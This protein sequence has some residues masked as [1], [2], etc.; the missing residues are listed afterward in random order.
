[1]YI[2]SAY[3]ISAAQ[4]AGLMKKFT[5]TMNFLVKQGIIE[6]FKIDS[7]SLGQDRQVWFD[8]PYD[9]KTLQM[10]FFVANNLEEIS[11]KD[12][13]NGSMLILTT[14][15]SCDDIKS[16]VDNSKQKRIKGYEVEKRALQI[17]IE[18]KRNDFSIESVS[19]ASEY[20][21]KVLKIDL[22]VK[23]NYYTFD[24]LNQKMT[25]NVPIQLKSSA[26]GQ[27]IH[28]KQHPDIP[29]IVFYEKM[30]VE[31]FIRLVKKIIQNYKIFF[32]KKNIDPSAKP[33]G[34]HI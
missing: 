2:E 10:S 32:H 11:K 7:D 18:E 33:E 28:K 30:T 31:N 26:K 21:D 5:E 12:A 6:N 1:M 20:E 24:R 23:V 29:S 9:D 14:D 19:H 13:I 8:F 25:L 34:L 22:V 27:M 17:I 3:T 4:D 16:F 15:L